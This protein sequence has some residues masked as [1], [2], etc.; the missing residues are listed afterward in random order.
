MIVLVNS[1]AV[2]RGRASFLSSYLHKRGKFICFSLFRRNIRFRKRAGDVSGIGKHYVRGWRRSEKW[3]RGRERERGERADSFRFTIQFAAPRNLIK[4][5][6]VYYGQFY[7]CVYPRHIDSRV[8]GLPCFPSIIHKF[9]P[10]LGFL[11]FRIRPLLSPICCLTNR[12]KKRKGGEK[13]RRNLESRP[14][15]TFSF[16]FVFSFFTSVFVIRFG[17]RRTS[18]VS[19]SKI[20]RGRHHSRAG[21]LRSAALR[22]VNA[23]R[24]TTNGI[25]A[26]APVHLFVHFRQLPSCSTLPSWSSSLEIPL[27]VP[28]ALRQGR[29]DGRVGV[30]LLTTLARNNHRTGFRPTGVGRETERVKI[31]IG[32]EGGGR[33]NG[34]RKIRVN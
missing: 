24:F 5:F 33:G 26:Y 22:P 16:L 25:Y 20:L 31:C 19:L 13:R 18:V 17:S 8:I 15:E 7:M 27:C 1:R 28:S 14:R 30:E 2:G 4:R 11:A 12:V 23:E 29:R 6:Y 9:H 10:L 3:A 21:C 34:T 32:E